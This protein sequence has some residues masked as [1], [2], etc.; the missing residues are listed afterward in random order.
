MVVGCSEVTEAVRAIS[1]DVRSSPTNP[2]GGSVPGLP[3]S[4]RK[5]RSIGKGSLSDS[6][7]FPEGPRKAP[8]TD[9]WVG[10]TIPVHQFAQFLWA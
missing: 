8:L 5:R 9:V 10:C 2:R 3:L 4:R 7:E 6:T 1:P